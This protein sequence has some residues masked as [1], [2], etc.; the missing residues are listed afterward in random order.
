M[1]A[2]CALCHFARDPQ[3]RAAPLRAPWGYSGA[4]LHQALTGPACSDEIHGLG[5]QKPIAPLNQLLQ[6]CAVEQRLAGGLQ[7]PG[8]SV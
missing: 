6:R 4:R 3:A 5:L 1:R 8:Q 2:L 7:F